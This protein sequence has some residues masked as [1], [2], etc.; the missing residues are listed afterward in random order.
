MSRS[1]IRGGARVTAHVIAAAEK[2]EKQKKKEK[3]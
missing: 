1:N 2:E 3:K